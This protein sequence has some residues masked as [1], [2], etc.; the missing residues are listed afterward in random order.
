MGEV[1]YTVLVELPNSVES[2]FATALLYFVEEELHAY[3]G[4]AVV[5]DEDEDKDTGKSWCQ[6]H[7]GVHQVSIATL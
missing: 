5:N 1:V 7:Y 3:D 4:E 6:V 2:I